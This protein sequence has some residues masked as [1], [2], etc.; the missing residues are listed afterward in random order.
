MYIIN[1]LYNTPPL[2]CDLNVYMVKQCAF[3]YSTSTYICNFSGKQMHMS[4][5]LG[6]EAPYSCVK[7]NALY[8]PT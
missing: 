6:C 3:N 1:P 7:I 2:L 8:K 5:S 4:L